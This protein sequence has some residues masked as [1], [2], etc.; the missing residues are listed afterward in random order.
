[1]KN[2]SKS[3]LKWSVHTYNWGL[4]K[5][6]VIS[7]KLVSKLQC[8]GQKSRFYVIL[9]APSIQKTGLCEKKW[10]HDKETATW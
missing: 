1:M 9:G 8:S 10:S 5:S 6:Y 7:N 3:K 2:I 4:V